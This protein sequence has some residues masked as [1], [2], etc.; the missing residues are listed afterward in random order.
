MATFL[1]YEITEP[2]GDIVYDV[3]RSA[4]TFGI[5]I[6][7]KVMTQIKALL[8]EILIIPCKFNTIHIFPILTFRL[9]HST[10]CEGWLVARGVPLYPWRTNSLLPMTGTPVRSFAVV[11]IWI[12]Y[13]CLWNTFHT[14]EFTSLTN[15]RWNFKGLYVCRL[16]IEV[17]VDTV[18]AGSEIGS[19]SSLKINTKQ[20]L[21]SKESRP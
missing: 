21:S 8:Y 6:I 11:V 2:R 20:M 17:S 1:S 7:V 16:I 9:N 15:I 18:Y 12:K 3:A 14:I 5:L 10:I 13:S 19:L 4:D